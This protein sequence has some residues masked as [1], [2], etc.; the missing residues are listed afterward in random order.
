MTHQAN[1]REVLGCDASL[2]ECT[3]QR[4]AVLVLQDGIEYREILADLE[5]DHLPASCSGRRIDRP[6]YW[7]QL[8]P[9]DDL[10]AIFSEEQWHTLTLP[11][12]T[13]TTDRSF[14]QLRH[15]ETR[16]ARRSG[17]AYASPHAGSPTCNGSSR[18]GSLRGDSHKY[19]ANRSTPRSSS[20]RVER[21]PGIGDAGTRTVRVVRLA[22]PSGSLLPSSPTRPIGAL[23]GSLTYRQSVYRALP[24]PSRVEMTRKQGGSSRTG[25]R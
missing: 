11:S 18:S 8:L 12:S 25:V 14:P 21:Q 10:D 1:R 23:R 16:S 5:L 24:Q 17:T 22:A 3:A 15:L 20:G 4:S 2:L 7:L 19:G 6:E 9:I 13:G